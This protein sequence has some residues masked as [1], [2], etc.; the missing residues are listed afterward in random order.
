MIKVYHPGI[1]I[2]YQ[3]AAYQGSKAIDHIPA[4]VRIVPVHL[5]T[6]K[7]K[8][9]TIVERLQVLESFAWDAIFTVLAEKISPTET[10]LFVDDLYI[11][12]FEGVL[13]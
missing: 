10:I 2:A 5:H 7:E 6:L 8:V 3:L 11:S 13:N 9:R 4:G 12:S 1:P